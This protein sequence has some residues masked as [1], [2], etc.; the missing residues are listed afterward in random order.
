[1]G[2]IVLSGVL[3][4]GAYGADGGVQSPGTCGHLPLT[5]HWVPLDNPTDFLEAERGFLTAET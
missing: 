4:G 5:D 3:D 2:Y 1:M